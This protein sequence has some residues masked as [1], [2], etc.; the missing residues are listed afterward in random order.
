MRALGHDILDFYARELATLGGGGA[1]N[2]MAIIV[3]VKPGWNHRN[4]ASF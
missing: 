1:E 4:M 2:K 3:L